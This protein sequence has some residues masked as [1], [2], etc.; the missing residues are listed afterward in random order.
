MARW[1]RCSPPSSA[2]WFQESLSQGGLSLRGEPSFIQKTTV[3]TASLLRPFL[4]PEFW[5]MA[6]F[7]LV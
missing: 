3:P 7:L 1:S 6:L 2:I 4:C 5:E